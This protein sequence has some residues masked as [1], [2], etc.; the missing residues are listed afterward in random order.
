MISSSG[1]VKLA[2]LGLGN[3]RD[4]GDQASLTISDV[5][6]GTPRYMPPEQ[7][8]GL[9]RVGPSGDIWAM[10]A[11]LYFLLAGKDA[12]DANSR[13]QV[14]Q[15]VC[16]EPFPD[17]TETVELPA[18]LVEVLERCTARE[19]SERYGHASELADDLESLIGR[20]GFKASLSDSETG[21]GTTRC[22]MVSPPP[23]ELLAK[24]RVHL[25][26][27]RDLG[28]QDEGLLDG[29]AT[30]DWLDPVNDSDSDDERRR[31]RVF[32][33]ALLATMVCLLLAFAIGGAL[34]FTGAFPR[35]VL[36]ESP[37]RLPWRKFDPLR[38]TWIRK[39]PRSRRAR[40]WKVPW[41]LPRFTRAKKCSKRTNRLPKRV[42]SFKKR[43]TLFRRR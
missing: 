7:S 12:Y 19:P 22:E 17:I 20:H 40:G 36:M 38:R 37:R 1:E 6:M 2:D 41:C 39:T 14:M 13:T 34:V 24:V 3:V 42:S 28:F 30:E 27:L 18:D 25:N 11:T 23:P 8:D 29:E 43:S 4:G 35:I 9:G 33:I 5:T 31:P 32:R 21:T 16:C 10:G 26:D 15:Q